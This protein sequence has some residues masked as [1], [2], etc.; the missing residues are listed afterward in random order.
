MTA[1]DPAPQP[2]RR[3]LRRILW[4]ALVVLV[5]LPALIAVGVML[6]LRSSGVRKAVL[7]KVSSL[8]AE[9][10][11][12]AFTA[13]DFSPLWRRSGIELRHVRAG[14]PGAA[15]LAT[16][17]R[18]EAVIDL[19]SLSDR[20]LIV[21][22]LVADGL[23]IDLTAPLP[24][25]PESKPAAGGPPVEVQKITIRN[26]EV[27]G[28]PL[29]KPA[30]DW[31][32]SWNVQG[33][34]ARGAY[35][36]DRLD[37]EVEEAEA[38][39]DRPGFGRQELRLTG[40]V[41][42]EDKKPLE[43]GELRVTGDGLRLAAS[44]TAGLAP[45]EP[46][47]V[48]FDLDAEPRALVAGLPPRGQIHA[49]GRL[50]LPESSGHVNVT[51]K[52][53]PA[54]ALKPYLDPK[55]YADL[56]LAGTAVDLQAAADLGPGDLTRAVG[57]GQINWKRG[58]TLARA[59][60]QIASQ[61]EIKATV[62]ADLLPGSPG[63]RSLQGTLRA[64]GWKEMANA[65]A[66]NAR[67]QL[68]LPDVRAALAEV[69][70][71]WPRLIPAPPKGVP[72]QGSLDADV[73][74]SGP[75]AS[76]LTS[77]DATWL[78]Q[79]GSRS[80]RES[81][82]AAADVE[83]LGEGRDGG[84]SSADARRVLP[85][86]PGLTGTVTGT[87]EVSGTRR[88]YRTR[89]EA[90]TAALAFPPSLEKLESGTVKADGTLV[91]KPFSYRG[92]LAVDGAGLVARPSASAT[93]RLARF[94]LTADGTLTGQAYDGTLSL[95]GTGVEVPG[96]ARVDHL[97]VASQGKMALDLSSFAARG[98]IDADR[99]ALGEPA[100]EIRN[101]HVEAA[102]DGRE[103]RLSAFSA[104]L[105]GARTVSGSGR[106][107]I[108]PLLSEADLDL[109][110][111]KP[112]D[113]L[114]A[115][116]LTARL[117]NG[118][119]EL[120]A[121]RLDTAS[122]PASL[123]ARIPLGSLKQVPQ[124]AAA[125]DAIPGPLA[126]GPVTLSL[127]AP[128]LDSE[129]LLAAL[130]LEPR[131]E[132]VR[133]GVSADLTLD[134][135][136]PAAGRGEVRLSG[137]TVETPDGRVAA[138]G[139]AV[140]RLAEGRL[141]LPP[142][143]LRIDGGALQGAG[144][145]LQASADLARSWRPFE[146]P[147][148]GA[149]TN[150]AAQASGTIDAALLNPYL[151]GGIAAGSL[152]VS[153]RASGSPDHL[154][155]EVRASGP[156]VSVVWPSPAARV[157]DPK[158]ALDLEDGRWTI[159][160]GKVGMNGGTVDLAGG[161]SMPGGAQGLDV[162][163]RL[164]GVR[165]RL[166]LTPGAGVDTLLSGRLHFRAPPDGRAR[167]AGNVTV[168]RGVLD[169]DL[170]LDR[171]VFTLLF[172]PR[173][174]PTT[175]ESALSKVDLDLRIDTIDGVRVKNNVGDLRASWR[176]LTVGGTLEEPVPRGR[177]DLDPGGLLLRLRPDRADRQRL[178]DL[179][180][181]PA[182]DPKVELTT[183]SSFQDPTISQLRGGSPLDLLAQQGQ[184][185]ET[186]G[187][188]DTRLLLASGLASYF[189][190]D[191][192]RRLSESVGLRGFSLRPVLVFSETDPS[193]RLTVGRDL[194]RQVSFAI[195][196][197]L[198]NA[199]RQTYVLYLQELS[200]LPGLR[201]EGFSNDLG[202]QGG[203]LQQDLKF[204][205]SGEAA[206]ESGP[207]LRRLDVSTPKKGISKRAVRGAIRLREEAAGAR[208]RGLHRRGGLDRPAAPEGLFRP[209]DHGRHHARGLAARLGGRG[210]DRGARPQSLLRLRGRQASPGPAAGDHPPLSHGFLRGRLDRRDAQGRDACLPQRRLSR[211]QGGDRGP[212]RA[213][214]G[215]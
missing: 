170:N 106:V 128:A 4:T 26:G 189:G 159:R 197:D 137:L 153:A 72:L 76:P 43:I 157:T 186:A 140:L 198:R 73:R 100:T 208:G 209:T 142:V 125:L 92:T 116:D 143:H 61:G 14:A 139:P 165:F 187:A 27:R 167:L 113:A 82:G 36:N 169:R 28:A 135:A 19:G 13:E 5:V 188:Q 202:H 53:I 184:Q 79:A 192:L 25:I 152:A 38:V 111:V 200:G 91:P 86:V 16:A 119:V 39:L 3:R 101:L 41:G 148:A 18:V 23:R 40:R 104:E 172:K 215:P 203:S 160:E 138:E 21:R 45:G 194:S 163:A 191:V 66:E 178:A 42:Y 81:Q 127:N 8:L 161:F 114:A 166:D 133:A 185:G 121:P 176:Q 171:E 22:S 190:A 65:T 93:A 109:H 134:L 120:D 52:E 78:P 175:E 55:I 156:S 89:V 210:R 164:A 96:Q 11:G 35:R 10:Y 199:E 115:A 144:I 110:L 47:A 206:R 182:T 20:P 162:E 149:V 103:V 181:R 151:Q 50:A 136:A 179:H 44:G 118:I 132:R 1:P 75:L 34:A 56:A 183:T 33:I 32:R 108:Q 48:K 107:V 201:L 154:V 69:R 68:Q 123:K 2:R 158:I 30:A 213:A 87:A 6:A 145:D 37:L 124:L 177:I 196:V 12:L 146:D 7:A 180:R 207:R 46:T 90:R 74:L 129:P 122:G 9:E 77:L 205:G 131:P 54:E 83:R 147:V 195:S 71:L 105:P 214:R 141:E 80:T 102:G 98:R 51:A 155:A 97:Q 63:R 168:E 64:A 49:T 59:D 15:P 31:V 58:R 88:G 212:A 62:T 174:T 193:A 99:L 84:S 204:G 57:G 24:K 150:L 67:V 94:S 173:E 112:L 130:G 211:S 126:Q 85:G 70:S 95:D 117:R 60:V 17:E 29:V